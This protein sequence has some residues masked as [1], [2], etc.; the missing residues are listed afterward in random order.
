ME[1]GQARRKVGRSY[2]QPRRFHAYRSPHLNRTLR[3]T[4]ALNSQN[5]RFPIVIVPPS[6]NRFSELVLP[7]VGL[8]ASLTELRP[9]LGSD[10]RVLHLAGNGDVVGSLEVLSPC[11]NL[12]ACRLGFTNVRGNISV[13][14]THMPQLVSLMLGGCPS[15]GG[16]LKDETFRESF[17]LCPHSLCPHHSHQPHPTDRPNAPPSPWSPPP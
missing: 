10:L 3:A 17:S 9:L 4:S 16:E 7:K 14:S 15:V 12:T 6:T 11:V 2:T 5:L 8:A 1:H 13:F